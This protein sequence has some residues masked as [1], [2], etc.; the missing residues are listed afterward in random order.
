MDLSNFG[1]RFLLYF[2][3]VVDLS[4][5]GSWMYT[6]VYFSCMYTVIMVIEVS[7]LK[8]S[9]SLILLQTLWVLNKL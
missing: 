3:D 2:C 5:S 6:F 8:V 7:V 9:I 4:I 1:V